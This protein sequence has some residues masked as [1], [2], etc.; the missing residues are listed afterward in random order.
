M[1]KTLSKIVFF[2]SGPVAAESLKLLAN[3]FEIEAVITKPAKTRSNDPVPVLDLAN[4]LALKTFTPSNKAELD[5]LFSTGPVQSKI[6]ILVDYGIIVSQSVINYFPLGIINSHFSLLPEWRGADPI[7]FS[8]LSGQK[9]TGVSIMIITAGMDEGPLIGQQSIKIQADW[10]SNSLTEELIKL[11]YDLLLKTMPDYING[12]IKPYKQST[13]IEASY[14]KKLIKEDGRINWQKPAAQ[15]EREIRAYINWPKSYS[16]INSLEVIITRAHVV[17][18]Q[19]DPGKFTLKPGE[20]IF[21]CGKD[22]LSIDRLKPINKKDM[23]I[24]SFLA[25]YKNLLV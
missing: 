6:A 20:L 15:I 22:A 3:N 4:D 1:K 5:E 11:S 23:D 2:G 17:E 14:S 10:D 25:G 7:T 13:D 18:E 9:T 12:S 24:K 21:Y 19:G 16:K 8:L